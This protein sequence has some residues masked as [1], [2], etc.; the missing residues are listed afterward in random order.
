MYLVQ[1]GGNIINSTIVH[2]P[3]LQQMLPEDWQTTMDNALNDAYIYARDA[4]T[5]LVILR[6]LKLLHFTIILIFSLILGPQTQK[7]KK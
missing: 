5:K 7:K 3:E 1:T 4:L 6:K 2:N